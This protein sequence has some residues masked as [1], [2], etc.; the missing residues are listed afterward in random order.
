[1]TSSSEGEHAQS[2]NEP[3]EDSDLISHRSTSSGRSLQ[4]WWLNSS[5]A[6]WWLMA[7]GMAL[8]IFFNK[9]LPCDR[10]SV[11]GRDKI[12]DYSP[13]PTVFLQFENPQKSSMVSHRAPGPISIVCV[14]PPFAIGLSCA[15]SEC[16]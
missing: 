4:R 13:R 2:I 9:E 11:I 10:L 16:K 8:I 3:S 5:N 12:L 14:A 7:S 15:L 1:M 6:H